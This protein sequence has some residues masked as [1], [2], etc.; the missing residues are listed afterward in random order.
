M[1]LRSN[2]F[3]LLHFTLISPLCSYQQALL[4]LYCRKIHYIPQVMWNVKYLLNLLHQQIWKLKFHR[5]QVIWI[6]SWIS[7]VNKKF[8]KF[9]KSYNQI[10]GAFLIFLSFKS[11]ILRITCK[12]KENFDLMQPKGNMFLLGDINYAKLLLFW[13]IFII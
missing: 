6:W 2:F 1:F 13:G 4:F 8:D 3:F 10:Y 11:I 12:M 9:L 7:W 5:M